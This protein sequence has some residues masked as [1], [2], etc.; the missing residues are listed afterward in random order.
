MTVLNWQRGV[1]SEATP[2]G[3][4][5]VLVSSFTK[6]TRRKQP[7]DA[8]P[9]SW[10]RHAWRGTAH[11]G[12]AR[13]DDRLIPPPWHCRNGSAMVKFASPFGQAGGEEGSTGTWSAVQ[14][15]QSRDGRSSVIRNSTGLLHLAAP[16]KA[17]SVAEKG[18]PTR[19][20]DPAPLLPSLFLSSLIL[21]LFAPDSHPATSVTAHSAP[22]HTNRRS[23]S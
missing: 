14:V 9:V 3:I 22:T 6:A 19:L 13:R 20:A 15:G 11:I 5:P 10:P 17:R 18:V 16:Q 12:D 8:R 4:V 7:V 1:L 2:D 21:V 23:L